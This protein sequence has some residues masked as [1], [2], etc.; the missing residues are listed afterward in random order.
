MKILSQVQLST[1]FALR[2]IAL[3]TYIFGLTLTLPWCGLAEAAEKAS[4]HKTTDAT[5]DRQILIRRLEIT[6][7]CQHQ[8]SY[9]DKGSGADSDL[10][11]YLPEPES[12]YYFLGAYAQQNYQDP[13]GC[14]IG[15][16][17]G[18][19]NRKSAKPLLVPPV[20]WRMIW[21]DE[22]SNADEGGSFW[23]AVPPSKDYVCLG[24]IPQI[25]YQKPSV[26]RYAC[27]HTCLVRKVSR[28]NLLWSDQGSG[29][30]RKVGVFLLPH[31]NALLAAPRRDPPN[32]A[33]DL[34][35][36]LECVSD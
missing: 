26:P 22:G 23:A 30:K 13:T 4:G 34:S 9:R 7:V 5:L 24:S 29:A 3:G 17:L 8:P 33:F 25:G 14:V 28:L 35:A 16:R 31:A 6:N 1:H 21:T 32:S 15:A 11:T 27:V 18:K 12:G 19:K 36:D 20:D 2:R 10:A